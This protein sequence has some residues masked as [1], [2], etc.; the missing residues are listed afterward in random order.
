MIQPHPRPRSRRYALRV[1]MLLLALAPTWLT[2]HAASAPTP[3]RAAAPPPP[4]WLAANDGPA[5]GTLRLRWLGTAGFELRTDRAQ[6]LIDPYLSRL[7]LWRLLTQSARPDEKQILAHLPRVNGVKRAVFVGHGHFDHMLDAATVARLLGAPL[8]ASADTLRVVAAEGLPASSRLTVQPGQRIR[9]GDIEIEA[10]LSAHSQMPTQWLAGGAIPAHPRLPM[11][12]L[13]YKNGPVYGFMIHWGGRTIYH[14]GS[15]DISE[16]ALA[17]RHADMA[18]VC[19]SGWTSNR[20]LFEKIQ[21]TL[22]PRV[23]MPMH[24]DDF[25]RPFDRGFVENPLADQDE[26]RAAIRQAM[27]QASV[28]DTAFFKVHQLS[29]ARPME[30]P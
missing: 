10:V 3:E 8:Y 2:L 22:A 29:P 16:T 30:R 26:A 25:F 27:P 28:V 14:C 17:G 4:N 12:F 1:A 23:I 20:R 11:A 15:A 19:L 18:L 5:P 7:E 24:H 13:D 6:I 21:N 9:V